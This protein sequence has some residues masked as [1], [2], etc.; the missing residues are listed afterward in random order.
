MAIEIN[1]QAPSTL[2][3]TKEDTRVQVGRSEPNIAR[4]ATGKPATPDT[5]TLTETAAQLHHL[6]NTLAQ[7]PVVDMSRV[8]GVKSVLLGGTYEINSDR[9]AEKMMHF[10]RALT[11]HTT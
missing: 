3:N 11:A 9:V 8:E 5:V 10:E 6:E 7:L 2:S 4:Q 1:G